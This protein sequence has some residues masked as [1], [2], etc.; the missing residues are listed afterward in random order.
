MRGRETPFPGELSDAC[1][2]SPCQF[3]QVFRALVGMLP[4]AYQLQLRVCHARGLLLNG[5]PV[6]RA[7]LEADFGDQAH[8]TRTFKRIVGVTPA[9]YVNGT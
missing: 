1:G 5:V 9:W 8:L 2:L 6:A 3:I 7:A 4:Y